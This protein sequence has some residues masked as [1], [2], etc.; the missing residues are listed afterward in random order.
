MNKFQI[1]DKNGNAIIKN[2][3]DKEV[4]ELFDV[5]CHPK[6]YCKLGKRSDFTND[7][8]GSWEYT[9]VPNWF[10]TIGWSL[11]EGKSLQDIYDDY[12][13][14]L[15]SVEGSHDIKIEEAFPYEIKLLT[16]WINKGYVGKAL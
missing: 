1:L 12:Q 2:D 4:C 10:D 14:I 8:K 13:K 15:D 9:C 11:S 6:R 16:H 3:L 5:P 7:I